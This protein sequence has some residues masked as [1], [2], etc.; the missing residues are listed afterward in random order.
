[1]HS[2]WL[3]LALALS[4]GGEATAPAEGTLI[5]L[6]NCNSIVERTTHGEIGHAALV[7]HEGGECFV[8]EATPGKVRRVTLAEYHAELARLNQRRKAGDQIRVW[9]LRPK[10]AYSAA[11]A[12]QMREFLDAQ[13]GRRYSV[14]NYVKG[15]PG[16]VHATKV[17]AIKPPPTKV[18]V[19]VNAANSAG[20]GIHCA[21]LT[22]T[23]LNA[24]GRYAFENCH[25]LNPQA[26]YTALL[27]THAA[28]EEQKI[29]PLAAREPWCQRAQRRTA[30]WFSWCGWSCREAWAWCW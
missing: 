9:L 26:L 27:P 6:E 12:D 16:E 13:L 3:C 7:F 23:T 2:F 21:E 30:E 8:Y 18:Q 1:M 24:S 19:A 11:E 25:R 29:A 17:G 4:A 20:G 28:P 15:K 22:A 5:F 14:R 10:T